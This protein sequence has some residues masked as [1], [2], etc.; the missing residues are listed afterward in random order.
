MRI[1]CP[2]SQF[3]VAGE[4]TYLGRFD[5]KMQ[6]DFEEVTTLLPW[7]VARHGTRWERIP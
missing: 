6:L 1:G 7:H 4:Q 3:E 2:G 5:A